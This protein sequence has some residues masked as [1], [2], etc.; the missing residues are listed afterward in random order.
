MN[1][2]D[3]FMRLVLFFDLPTETKVQRKNYKLFIKYLKSEGYIRV[4]YSVYSKLCINTDSAETA[5]KKVLSNA[6]AQGDIR[7][8]V[9]TEKQYQKITNVNE[10]HTLQESITNTNRVIMIGG[11][12]DEDKDG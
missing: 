2:R 9:I 5:S 12:N 3:S 6:P 10:T 8:I 1:Q 4:Q 11:M 7:F